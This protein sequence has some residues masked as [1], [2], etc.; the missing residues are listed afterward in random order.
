MSA[1]RLEVSGLTWR[2]LGRPEPVLRGIDLQ[3]GAGERVLLSGPSGAGKSTLLLALAGQLSPDD[4]DLAG[5]VRAPGATGLL[6]QDPSAAVVAGRAGRDTAFGPENRA[7]PRDQIWSRVTKA[8]RESGFPYDADRPTSALSGGEGQRLALAGALA[9]GP[10]LLLLDEPTSMLDDAAAATVRAA[11]IDAVARTG[12]TLV[13]VDH[14]AAPWLAHVD[15]VVTLTA[16]GRIA[17]DGPSPAAHVP[18]S[19]ATPARV[20]SRA[21]GLVATQGRGG[22]RVLVEATGVVGSPPGWRRGLPRPRVGPVDARVVAGAVTTIVGQSGAGKST[23]LALLAGLAEPSGGQL[24]ADAQ[25]APR[26]ERRPYRWRSRELAARVAWLP[27]LPEHALVA[28]TVRDEVAATSRALGR[29]DPRPVDALID[30]LGLGALAGQ[31]PHTLSGGEQRRLGLAAA[32]AH[33]PQVLLLD[34][35]TVGQD[36]HTWR[37]VV[38]TVRAAADR[39][40]A[41]VVATHDALLLD[42]LL[43]DAL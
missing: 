22:G 18:S 35:P 42:A 36:P 4:G 41:V 28:A 40:T 34:E 8:M 14:R 7:L 25:W 2:P 13:V 1:A 24:L 3:I 39:G 30:A 9:L 32:L 21:S 15:R 27:Q 23:L 38:D 20:A 31:D 6:L 29:D 16:D 11:V 26:G 5:R 17:A 12:C 19:A 33:D 10:G 37:Q 43:P